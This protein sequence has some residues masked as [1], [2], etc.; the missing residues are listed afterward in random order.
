MNNFNFFE[1][2]EFLKDQFII[3]LDVLIKEKDVI[4]LSDFLI[5]FYGNLIYQFKFNIKFIEDNRF[6]LKDFDY[7]LLELEKRRDNIDFIL[8]NHNSYN[9]TF[10]SFLSDYYGFINFSLNNLLHK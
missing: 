1:L 6:K 3:G 2:K 7:L 10:T 5:N 9:A 8:K 4:K